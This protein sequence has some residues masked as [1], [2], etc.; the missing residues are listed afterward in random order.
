MRAR[1]H[2]RFLFAIIFV[3]YESE[4]QINALTGNTQGKWRDRP[5]SRC[6][7]ARAIN[8]SGNRH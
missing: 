7:A 6:P 2:I 8:F 3:S 1:Y 5:E 4:R